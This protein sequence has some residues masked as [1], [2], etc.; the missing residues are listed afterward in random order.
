MTEITKEHQAKL[1]TLDQNVSKL[2]QQLAT[3]R[4]AIQSRILASYQR[5]MNSSGNC[6]TKEIDALRQ[7]IAD[8]D[9]SSQRQILSLSF[10]SDGSTELSNT[11]TLN[12]TTSTSSVL[13][14]KQQQTV[15]RNIH[16]KQEAPTI[17]TLGLDF[18]HGH[19]Y[20]TEQKLFAP[21]ESVGD[22]HDSS[23]CDCITTKQELK[24]CKDY[25]DYYDFHIVNNNG[26]DNLSLKT[27]HLNSNK[28]NKV[29]DEDKIAIAMSNVDANNDNN[30]VDIDTL[31]KN[32]LSDSQD[33]NKKLHLVCDICNLRCASNS[34]LE[35]H[36]RVHSGEKPYRC[37]I[38][39]RDFARKYTLDVHLRTHTGEKPYKCKF[40]TKSFTQKS[41]LNN[42]LIR[43]HNKIPDPNSKWKRYQPADE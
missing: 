28:Y 12:L 31:G 21:H 15:S 9:Q 39:D 33:S 2:L 6:N 17:P 32:E 41:T 4:S 42:H 24:D 22:D 16:I 25:N 3:A 5:D 23:I 43:R 18:D 27:K 38:C 20:N 14:D 8:F 29:V 36:E 13:F 37:S 7:T 10:E 11:N 1:V 34:A 35:R 19:N 40:C 30:C 26:N